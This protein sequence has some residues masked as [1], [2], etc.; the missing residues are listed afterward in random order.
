MKSRS[1][2]RGKMK[3]SALRKENSKGEG[4]NGDIIDLDDVRE[5]RKNDWEDEEFDYEGAEERESD[6]DE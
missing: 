2:G 3:N 1:S 5:R 6:L 4:A